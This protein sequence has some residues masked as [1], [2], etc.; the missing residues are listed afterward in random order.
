MS[1]HQL[2]DNGI[3]GSNAF[4][5][6]P[7]IPDSI[8]ELPQNIS[9]HEIIFNYASSLA[10]ESTTLYT[11]NH[12]YK[13]E[14]GAYIKDGAL[15]SQSYTA[16]RRIIAQDRLSMAVK[17]LAQI[18]DRMAVTYAQNRGP[19][20]HEPIASVATTRPVSPPETSN[21]FAVLDMEFEPDQVA[22]LC[23]E[24]ISSYSSSRGEERRRQRLAHHSPSTDDSFEHLP[25][26][27]Q[28]PP[29]MIGNVTVNDVVLIKRYATYYLTCAELAT[30]EYSPLCGETYRVKFAKR[31][32]DHVIRF[33]VD[34]DCF[35]TYARRMTRSD[36]AKIMVS[37]KGG[38]PSD[39]ESLVVDSTSINTVSRVDPTVWFNTLVYGRRVESGRILP[40][41]RPI[42]DDVYSREIY[43]KYIEYWNGVGGEI[44]SGK[45]KTLDD[46]SDYD[47][48]TKLNSVVEYMTG[49][50][51]GLFHM[52]TILN[53]SITHRRFNVFDGVNP[54]LH[55]S[56]P[57]SRFM[58][59][60]DPVLFDGMMTK[61][62]SAAV[63]SIVRK[64]VVNALSIIEQNG[65]F[66]KEMKELNQLLY[67]STDSAST[68][69]KRLKVIK[70]LVQYRS[71]TTPTY[72]CV[73]EYDIE[74]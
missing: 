72:Y 39:I 35:G 23:E 49:N 62:I 27:P 8:P 73:V 34:P 22:D 17:R 14:V 16:S 3:D 64:R 36:F 59:V 44:S 42:D 55:H 2:W 10:T 61:R 18:I 32:K 4:V 38:D 71:H 70:D 53:K 11:C 24:W 65:H 52:D 58:L 69:S 9:S 41:P 30:S 1:L 45:Y 19:I 6:T 57:Q 47:F 74:L 54:M 46:K 26:A 68:T 48:Y 67:R 21:V 51:V 12:A 13:D 40:A 7:N 66:V 20:V 31:V 50:I 28:G 29:I 33:T 60:I 56:D 5:M 63:E 43:H 37:L 15:P 25:E